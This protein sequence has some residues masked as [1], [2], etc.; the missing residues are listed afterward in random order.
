[1]TGDGRAD[2]LSIDPM[3]GGLTLWQNGCTAM[4]DNSTDPDNDNG[5]VLECSDDDDSPDCFGTTLCDY[6][7]DFPT[8]DAVQAA[9][10]SF[11]ASCVDYYAIRTLRNM[12]QDTVG[13]FA[14]ADNGYDALYGYYVESVKES[15]PTALSTFMLPSDGQGN[16]YFT[17]TFQAYDSGTGAKSGHPITHKCPITADETKFI[18]AYTIEYTLEEVDE[19]FD[20]LEAKYGIEKD[21]V[22]F[23]D[24]AFPV[25]CPQFSSC[26]GQ[27]IVFL[28][29]PM[30]SDTINVANPKDT[31]TAALANLPA[32]Q[33]SIAARELDIMAGQW[34]GSTNDIVSVVSMPVMM[35]QQ[36]IDSMNKA[37]AIGKAQKAQDKKNLIIE[38][39]SAI[40]MFIP[41]LDDIVPAALAVAKVGTLIGDAGSLA[42][43]IEAVVSDPD[44][45]PMA[46]LGILGGAGATLSD[47]SNMAKLA[48]ARRSMSDDD[49]E[50]L[51]PEFKAVND[52][53][54]EL[55]RP[56]CRF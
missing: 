1:M 23:D 8:L 54:S 15:V 12:L 29:Y 22:K 43:T 46:I 13:Q 36:A 53:L 14:S 17:C 21:W 11:S 42:V 49:I 5:E 41:F 40:L 28:N 52:E 48:S 37:K 51:G 4:P 50:G 18:E 55:E 24:Q 45:A 19:F 39:L 47:A 44:S 27:G 16:Q 10:G 33:N 34:I 56:S 35:L 31:V 7:Q 30:A 38:I 2:Y 25:T 6:S 20:A 32:T 9:L 26:S 3:T